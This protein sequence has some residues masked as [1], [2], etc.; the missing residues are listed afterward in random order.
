MIFY[1]ENKE[2]SLQRTTN[3]IRVFLNKKKNEKQESEN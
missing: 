1:N 2:F 3:L